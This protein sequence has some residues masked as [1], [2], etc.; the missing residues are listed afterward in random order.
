M[1]RV[2]VSEVKA[3]DVEVSEASDYGD[4]AEDEADGETDEIEGVHVIW[5]SA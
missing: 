1:R 3:A 2:D 4:E 5:C